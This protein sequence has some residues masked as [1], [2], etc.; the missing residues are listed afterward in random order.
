MDNKIVSLVERSDD[1]RTWPVRDMLM[2]VIDEI[3]RGVFEPDGAVLITRDE[4]GSQKGSFSKV[5]CGLTTL[6]IIGLIDLA[7]YRYLD[8]AGE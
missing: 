4:G 3:D 5:N 1:S 2:H 6:E 7:K 8:K